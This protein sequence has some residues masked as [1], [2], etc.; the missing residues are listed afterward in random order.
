MDI[1][2][3]KLLKAVHKKVLNKVRSLKKVLKKASLLTEGLKKIILLNKWG[4][5]KKDFFYS[6]QKILQFKSWSGKRG[7]TL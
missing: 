1:L 5:S 6:Q 3:K 2:I 4:Q 7:C